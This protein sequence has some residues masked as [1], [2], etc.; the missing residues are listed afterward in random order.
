M[1]TDIRKKTFTRLGAGA[2]VLALTAALT[3]GAVTAAS[4]QGAAPTAGCNFYAVAADTALT[5]PVSNGLFSNHSDPECDP[6]SI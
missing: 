3:L 6:I 2:G 5:V 1:N 4:A